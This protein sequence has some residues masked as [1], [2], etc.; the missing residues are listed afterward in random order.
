MSKCM[1]IGGSHTE[2]VLRDY[3]S[4]TKWQDDLS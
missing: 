2:E 4:K 1:E 3:A